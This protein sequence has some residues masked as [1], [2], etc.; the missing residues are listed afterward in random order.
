MRR[1]VTL[2]ALLAGGLMLALLA[3]CGNAYPSAS[4]ECAAAPAG[5]VAKIKAAARSNF[6][7]GTSR[8]ARL[9]VGKTA[10]IPAAEQAYGTDEIM[11]A[12]VTSTFGGKGP[13]NQGGVQSTELFATNAAGTAVYPLNASAAAL[14]DLPQPKASGWSSWQK[15]TS[16]SDQATTAYYCVTSLF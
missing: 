14:F 3:G 4:P 11:A 9:D 6:V 15:Q 7:D 5:A 1:R 2:P 12:L 13:A 8:I 10:V 16:Q